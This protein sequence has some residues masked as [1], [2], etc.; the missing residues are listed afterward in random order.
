LFATNEVCN[1]NPYGM[2]KN[3]FTNT[4]EPKTYQLLK[5]LMKIPELSAFVLVGGTNLSLRYGHRISIDLDLFTNQPFDRIEV[6]EAVRKAFPQTIKLDE[7]KQTLWLNIDGIKVD[8]ILHEYPYIRPVEIIDEIRF[9][10]IEDIIPMKLEAMATRG[11]KKDFWDIA[12]LLDYFPL[13]QM[14]DFYQQKYTNSDVGH[15]VLSM[16]YFADA[17]PEKTNPL[18]LKSITW[19][20][21]KKK[22]K[23]TVDN[24]LK[25]QF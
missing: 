14:L 7:R 3:L 5:K 6:Y 11:V 19:E 9:M 12:E 25:Q 8:V 2:N 10:S 21:V 17:E 24:F 16:T 20:A 22:M 13:Y 1:E 15:I 23:L 18:T 4:V